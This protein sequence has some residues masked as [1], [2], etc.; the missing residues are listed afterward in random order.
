VDALWYFGL[1]GGAAA[2][3]RAA[4]GNMKRTWVADGAARDW[5]DTAQ[6]EG[7]EFLRES[8]QVKNIWVPAGA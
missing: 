1:R 7:E 6:G 3:E 2:I 5:L 8:T 4:S